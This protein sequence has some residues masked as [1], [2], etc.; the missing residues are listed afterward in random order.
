MS[1]Q[2]RRDVTVADIMNAKA[3]T[4]DES[5]PVGQIAAMMIDLDVSG[6]AVSRDDTLVG[7][8]TES[9]I[10]AWDADVD[11]PTPVPYFDA[12]LT[13]DAG[14]P[15]SD[16]VRKALAINAGQL[17]TS[18]VVSIRSDATLSE[19]ATVMIDRDIHPLPVVDANNAYVGIVSRR[20]LVRIIAEQERASA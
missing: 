12:I 8:V 17:M 13:A 16:E 6:L 20:D 2:T 19:C 5:T 18:P 15:Y 9:D 1:E 14:R 10:V 3:P 7:I 4:V 11:A